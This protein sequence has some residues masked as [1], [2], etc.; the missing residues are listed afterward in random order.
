LT[1]LVRIPALACNTYD[2]L[3]WIFIEY[4]MGILAKFD[5]MWG[6]QCDEEF[7][8]RDTVI[9][10]KTFVPEPGKIFPVFYGNRK[11]IV[12]FFTRDR[13]WSLS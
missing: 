3:D 7:Y 13:H 6:I 10:E 11:F 1:A 4:D 12:F 9:L 2:G 8:L 5:F